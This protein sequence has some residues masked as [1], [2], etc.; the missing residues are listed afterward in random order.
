MDKNYEGCDLLAGCIDTIILNL[1]TKSDSYGYQIVKQLS[2]L[3]DGKYE[4]KEATL[5]S[6]LKRLEK[7]GDIEWYWGDE[8]NGGR[9]KYYKITDS[10]KESLNKHK[11]H[12]EFT[13][14]IMSKTI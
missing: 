9:R 10:G 8:T 7:N 4:L 2:L 6:C 14:F 3:S 11:G 1:L 13:K 12:W 5:Y